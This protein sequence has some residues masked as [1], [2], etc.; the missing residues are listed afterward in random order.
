MGS[1]EA[2]YNLGKEINEVQPVIPAA[3]RQVGRVSLYAVEEGEI[4]PE[5]DES[6]T[7]EYQKAIAWDVVDEADATED[8]EE[9]PSG[10]S[11]S[12]SVHSNT[13]KTVYNRRSS[14]LDAM[15][16]H[17]DKEYTDKLLTADEEKELSKQIECGNLEA[18]REL[19]S[20]NLR[21]VARIAK[22]YVGYGLEYDDLAQLGMT[23]LIRASEKF[24]WRKGFKFSTY[25]TWWIKQAITRGLSDSGRTIR[26]PAH[27]TQQVIRVKKEESKLSVKLGREPTVEELAEAAELSPQDVE[28]TQ[29]AVRMQPSSV[30]KPTGDDPDSPYLLEKLSDGSDVV[31]T[32][33]KNDTRAKLD[34]VMEKYLDD[35]QRLAIRMYY[36]LIDDQEYTYRAIAD[37][38]GFSIE[39]VRQLVHSGLKLLNRTPGV[40]EDLGHEQ[41]F[42]QSET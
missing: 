21:L 41:Y 16:E 1:Q 3:T 26:L 24:D 12:V 34:N 31:E 17:A 33:I 19:I 20:R 37:E 18:K 40:A 2:A 10:T 5:L 13:V 6:D 9:A 23:G 14:S 42:Q 35:N 15:I 32:V 29:K 28:N 25:G 38:L 4:I 22:R 7:S 36:G 39:T 30:D 11:D 8:A 27:I